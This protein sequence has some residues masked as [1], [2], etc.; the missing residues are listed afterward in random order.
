MVSIPTATTTKQDRYLILI[1]RL[2]FPHH[3][4]TLKVPLEV[5]I[6]RDAAREKTHGKDAARVVYKKSTE[7][8]YGTNIDVNRPLDVC[9]KEIMTYLPAP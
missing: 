7:F 1:S 5:C 3:V 6:A 8:D 9:V 2:D 4:F